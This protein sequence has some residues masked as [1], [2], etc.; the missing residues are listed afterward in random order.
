MP[1][2]PHE[3]PDRLLPLWFCLGGV[4]FVVWFVCFGGFFLAFWLQPASQLHLNSNKVTCA[5]PA[6]IA[7]RLVQKRGELGGANFRQGTRD[8]ELG[9]GNWEQGTGP[10]NWDRQLG[11]G[12]WGQGTGTGNR[13]LGTGKW[14]LG[15][16]TWDRELGT[17][18]WGRELGPGDLRG[19]LRGLKPPS[20]GGLKGA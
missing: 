14:G 18:N 9:A 11:T 16:G 10:G 12:N 13:E 2:W 15:K 4:W 5:D 20:K 6:H 8:T 19:G 1:T 17:G 3:L 7:P